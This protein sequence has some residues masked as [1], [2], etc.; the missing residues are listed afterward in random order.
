MFQVIKQKNHGSTQNTPT[1]TTNLH[2]TRFS[3]PI[4]TSRTYMQIVL[5]IRPHSACSAVICFWSNL[6]YCQDSVSFHQFQV[7]V[8]VLTLYTFI[9]F[10]SSSFGSFLPWLTIPSYDLA[11]YLAPCSRTLLFLFIPREIH[12][13]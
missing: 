5:I 3:P 10:R 13:P 9:Y 4:S 7:C 8:T 6:L 1:D 11:E 2:T 12:L